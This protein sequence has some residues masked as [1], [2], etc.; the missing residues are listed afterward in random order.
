[1]ETQHATFYRPNSKKM[2]IQQEEEL[3]MNNGITKLTENGQL[4]LVRGKVLPTKLKKT[5]NIES[6]LQ[7]AKCSSITL[8]YWSIR[9]SFCKCVVT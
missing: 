4:K 1:M 7:I 5:I 6:L 9:P 3:T 8:Q 2:K